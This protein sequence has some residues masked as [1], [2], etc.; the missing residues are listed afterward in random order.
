VLLKRIAGLSALLT[1]FLTLLAS[2]TAF[3][4]P[5]EKLNR[6][7]FSNIAPG[8]LENEVIRNFPVR[9]MFQSESGKM[10]GGVF[11]RVFNASGIAIFKKMCEKPWLF[12]N[13]PA[14][15]YNVVAVDRNQLTRAKAFHVVGKEGSKQVKVKLSWPKKAVG[16]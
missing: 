1:V 5:V 3:S 4:Q 11:V 13:L 2:G 9:I 12:M 8:E 10:Y 16:Y 14:G 15:D 6:V 7:F